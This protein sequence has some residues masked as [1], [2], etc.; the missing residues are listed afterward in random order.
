MAPVDAARGAAAQLLREVRQDGAYANLAMPAILRTR[1]LTGRDAGFAIELGYGALRWQGWYD[2]VISAAARREASSIDG[3]MLDVLRLGCHQLLGMRVPAHAAVDSCVELARGAGSPGGAKGRAGFANAVLR[4]VAEQDADAWVAALG[5]EG[6]SVEALATRWSHPLWQ[7]RALADALGPRAGE[8]RDL[9]QADNEPT[10]PTLVARPGLMDVEE[11]LA[12]RNVVPGRWSPI[13]ARLTA[14][15][16]E[17]IAA[18]SD[19]RAGV[20]D[21][22]SQLVALALTRA[23]LEPRTG[24]DGEAPAEHAWLDLCAG[25]GG[26]TAILAGIAA[27]RG[28]RVTA[29]EL[30]PHRAELVRDSVRGYDDVDV[31]VGDATTAPWG[32]QAFDRVLV[33]APCSGLGALRRR[34]EARWRKTLEDLP[35][36]TALQRSLLMTALAAVRPGGVVAYVTCSP[37]LAETEVV[38]A[39][40]R[41]ATGTSLVDAPALLP[42]MDDDIRV[43]EC[44]QLWPHRH[45]TDAMFLALI[46]RPL[47]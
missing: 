12:E 44:V 43:G 9:L 18:V 34:P 46:R 3:P 33:D 15:Q 5:V 40:V 19:G 4:R 41:R 10:S 22:G 14:G 35:P 1:G 8:L 7:V 17:H 21:E 39:D 29:V 13:A 36:L 20:Q 28:V 26:K 45:G 24:P 23:P 27:Q 25:P 31:I 47:D 6:D 30:H 37:H 11:L 38:V 42:E 16:P 2:A 32:A